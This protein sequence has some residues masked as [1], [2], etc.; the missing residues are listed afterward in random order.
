MKTLKDFVEDTQLDEKIKVSPKKQIDP[1]NILLMR[2]HSIRQFANGQKVALYYVDKINK[3]VTI[4]Y[5]DMVWGEETEIIQDNILNRLSNI[6]E[7]HLSEFIDFEDGSKIKVDEQ[8]AN[9]VLK[10][11]AAAN[12][13][14]KEKISEMAHKSK[15]QFKEVVEFAW[16]HIQ[17]K[18]KG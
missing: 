8:T 7:S 11:H 6:V 16:K 10:L 4:P 1:P 3:L 15:A 14:N 17:H 18:N 5:S 9:V 13:E 12:N 2:R